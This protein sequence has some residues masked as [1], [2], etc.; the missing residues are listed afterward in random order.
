MI[1]YASVDSFIKREYVIDKYEIHYK[2]LELYH[3]KRDD[4]DMN[5]MRSS[6]C[7]QKRTEYYNDFEDCIRDCKNAKLKA[8]QKQTKIHHSDGDNGESDSDYVDCTESTEANNFKAQSALSSKSMPQVNSATNDYADNRKVGQQ[9]VI[10]VKKT[11]ARVP[12]NKETSQ[13]P[14]RNSKNNIDFDGDRS[15][16]SRNNE[17]T[18]NV[19][20]VESSDG[21]SISASSE[22]Q[23]NNISVS[24][25][26]RR[27]STRSSQ[28][29]TKSSSNQISTMS[30][31]VEKQS[32]RVSVSKTS[33]VT[34]K[35]TEAPVTSARTMTTT[36]SVQIEGDKNETKRRSCKKRQAKL[37]IAA[38]NTDS[39]A[40]EQQR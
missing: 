38:A 17:T 25:N 29:S 31:G 20:M 19:H 6:S 4:R 21:K 33:P 8:V 13:Q 1:S 9:L 32:S 3:A 12:D 30:I 27:T 10:D 18:R 36:S 11:A 5:Q 34:T 39:T 24:H 2:L 16:S 40:A 37:T 15:E 22:C 26:F 14:T 7:M 23:S 35:I 28:E